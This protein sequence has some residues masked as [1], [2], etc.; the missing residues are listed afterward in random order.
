MGWTRCRTGR[1]A[2]HDWELLFSLQLD[3]SPLYAAGFALV[4]TGITGVYL[5]LRRSGR[6][7][8]SGTV[9]FYMSVFAFVVTTISNLGFL[10]NIW[11]ARWLET[12][13]AVNILMILGT[14]MFGAAILKG[15]R[16]PRGGAWLLIAYAATEAGVIV[17]MAVSGYTLP[18]VLWSVPAFLFGLGWGW[19][20]YGLWSESGASATG[21][22]SRVS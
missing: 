7:G 1:P 22:S 4:V 21:Q 6:F 14:V 11:G 3:G 8:L 13:G 18:S 2:R 5:Y 20:G 19:L 17:A 9:G 10:L 12:L 16:L 15:R